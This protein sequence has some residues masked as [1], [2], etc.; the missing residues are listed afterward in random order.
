MAIDT[1]DY[2]GLQGEAI[3]E[4]SQPSPKK[5]RQ[6]AKIEKGKPLCGKQK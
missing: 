4:K 5:S 6:L 2:P 3:H 1:A